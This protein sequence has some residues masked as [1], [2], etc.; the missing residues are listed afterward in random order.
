MPVKNR[1][2]LR[3]ALSSGEPVKKIVV[4]RD[5]KETEITVDFSKP[6]AR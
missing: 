3:G 6:L 4:L 5:G 1:E 2:E